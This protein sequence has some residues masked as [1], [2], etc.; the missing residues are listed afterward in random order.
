MVFIISSCVSAKSNDTIS[1][2][3]ELEVTPIPLPVESPDSYQA[4]TDEYE[5]TDSLS[6]DS[7]GPVH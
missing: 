2:S 6:M 1:P 4:D 5:P 3:S 7:D